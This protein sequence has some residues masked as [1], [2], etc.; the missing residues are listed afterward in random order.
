MFTL[1]FVSPVSILA[2]FIS[3]MLSVAVHHE[4]KIVINFEC[5]FGLL[6]G[7]VFSVLLC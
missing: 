3:P 6:H 2:V 4:I 5:W 7:E 1:G